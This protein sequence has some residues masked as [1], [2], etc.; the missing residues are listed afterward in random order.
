ME[1]L[2]VR[3]LF[4]FWALW[5]VEELNDDHDYENETDKEFDEDIGA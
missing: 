2:S 4:V 5:L 3:C 1:I